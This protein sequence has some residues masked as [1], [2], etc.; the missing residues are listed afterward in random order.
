MEEVIKTHPVS[1]WKGKEPGNPGSWETRE[2][3]R[4]GLG[5]HKQR[6]STSSSENTREVADM[7]YDESF[8][9]AEI[10]PILV[11]VMVTLSFKTN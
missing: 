8:K 10:F 6:G 3:A 1:R 9:A 7:E 4:V 2:W 5:I 11:L